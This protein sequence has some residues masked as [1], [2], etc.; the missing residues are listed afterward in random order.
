MLNM[1]P[2]AISK[3]QGNQA[4]SDLSRFAPFAVKQAIVERNY[5]AALAALE[6]A[7]RGDDLHCPKCAAVVGQKP[8]PWAVRSWME[9][10]G[11]I[12]ATQQIILNLTQR[13]G[14]ADEHE[15]ATLIEEGRQMRRLSEEGVADDQAIEDATEVLA[16][17]L[18]RHPDQRLKVMAKLGGTL[19]E[20][21]GSKP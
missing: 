2:W 14:V 4:R 19:V 21:N 13:L 17:L 6:R 3:K 8:E 15:A 12:G 10:A 16:V 5:E 9:A 7:I 1:G 20:T 18:R 11:A